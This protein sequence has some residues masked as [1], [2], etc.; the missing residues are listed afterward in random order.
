MTEETDKSQWG[1]GPWQTEPD[2]LEWEDAETGLPC[3][4]RRNTSGA[5]CG[6]VGVSS[7]YSTY[8]QSYEELCHVGCHGGLTFSGWIDG[9]DYWWFGFDCAN[10]CDYCPA[11]AQWKR[12]TLLSGS[13]ESYKD[14]E[15]VK[16][17]VTGLAKQLFNPLEALAS[18]H[19]P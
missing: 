7:S 14:V 13:R 9:A 11:D 1:P 19:E 6:Y 18:V 5:L 2:F 17:Q 16:E 4:I 15:Y 3:Q 10:S 8:Q 12:V